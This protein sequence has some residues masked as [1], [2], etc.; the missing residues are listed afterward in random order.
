[1]KNLRA[2]EIWE[3]ADIEQAQKDPLSVL[4]SDGASFVVTTEK[5]TENYPLD[6]W[7]TDMDELEEYGEA[8]VNQVKAL[9]K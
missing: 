2:A 7:D 3:D 5:N 8:V 6:F 9:T 4:I 1:M